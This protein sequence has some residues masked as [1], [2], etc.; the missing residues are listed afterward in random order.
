MRRELRCRPTAADQSRNILSQGPV[1][2]FEKGR[3]EPPAQPQPDEGGPQLLRRPTAHPLGEA[4]QSAPPRDLLDLTRDP[5]C[6]HLPVACPSS[7]ALHP[8]PKMGCEG[9]AV[10]IQPLAGED[11]QAGGNELLTQRVD[12]GRSCVLGPSCSTGMIAASGVD[13]QPQPENMRPAAQ[14]GAQFI[15]LEMREGEVLQGALMQA[16]ALLA[17]RVSAR[18]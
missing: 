12:Q 1:H 14:A 13:R 6:C 4:H 9:R 15:Q 7:L 3:L 16:R 2:T 18:R 8:L 10:P 11:G 17:S 5:P